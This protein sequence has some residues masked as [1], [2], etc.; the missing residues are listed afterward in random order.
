MNFDLKKFLKNLKLN[1]ENI[2]MVMGAVV[3]VIVAVLVV[4]YFKHQGTTNVPAANTESGQTNVYTVKKG[5]TLW[6]I[7]ENEFGSGYNWTDIYN[8][9]NLKTENIE[10]G[11]ELTIPQVAP[12]KP[13]AT[14]EVSTLESATQSQSITGDTYTVVHGDDLWHIAVRAYGDGYQWVN[15]AK[16]NNLSNP[17]M[18]F[19]GNVLTLP[20]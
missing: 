1:E 8:T 20:R 19:N 15:I 4:N 9:N 6:S 16:A 17:N 11:Q 12:K 10:V 13:T 3:I 2:S 18:I 5:D 7:A 14:K